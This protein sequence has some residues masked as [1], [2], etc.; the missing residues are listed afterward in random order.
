MAGGVVG[1]VRV[2]ISARIPAVLV[3]IVQSLLEALVISAVA[4][5]AGERVEKHHPSED[6]GAGRQRGLPPR[7]GVPT[8]RDGSSLHPPAWVEVGRVTG[9]SWRGS[10]LAPVHVD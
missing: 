6:P 8:G 1:L 9:W 2:L 5:S 4:E 3:G 10:E 7:L